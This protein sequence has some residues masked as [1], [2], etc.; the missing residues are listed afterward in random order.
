[1]L[2]VSVELVLLVEAKLPQFFAETPV[3]ACLAEHDFWRFVRA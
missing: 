3:S 1:M 2:R